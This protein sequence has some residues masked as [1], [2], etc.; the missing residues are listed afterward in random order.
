MPNSLVG[1]GKLIVIYCSLPLFPEK[2]PP[3]LLLL[4]G[5]EKTAAAKG[6]SLLLQG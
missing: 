2:P 3:L 4:M 1:N 5:N 6:G